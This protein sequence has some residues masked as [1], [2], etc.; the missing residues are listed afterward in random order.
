[1]NLKI[2]IMDFQILPIDTI[3][4][5]NTQSQIQQNEQSIETKKVQ[6]IS[7][8]E[9]AIIC[10]LLQLESSDNT[11]SVVDK[12]GPLRL[13][14]VNTQKKN[15]ETIL[16]STNGP[17]GDVVNIEEKKIVC[18][19]HGH[20]SICVTNEIKLNSEGKFDLT[21]DA[22]E[23][24]TFEISKCKFYQGFEGTVIRVFKHNGKVYYSSHKK[25]DTSKS[26]WGSSEN[27][28]SLFLRLS[29]LQETDLFGDEPSYFY[30]YVFIVVAPDLLVSSK[31][32]I[33]PGYVALVDIFSDSSFKDSDL[34]KAKCL[35]PREFVMLNQTNRTIRTVE[36]ELAAVNNILKFGYYPDVINEV[37][38]LQAGEFVMMH[39]EDKVFRVES[40]AYNWR[41]SV[42]GHDPN[43]I[44]RFY[45][46]LQVA[47]IDPRNKK[48]LESYLT[49]FEKI[50]F[51]PIQ[52]V[53]NQIFTV[54]PIVC[55]VNSSTISPLPKFTDRIS[56]IRNMLYNLLLAC[57][58]H[59]QKEIIKFD[60]MLIEDR[61]N[62]S[63]WIKQIFRGD[64]VL[65]DNPDNQKA[66]K[67]IGDIIKTA[68]S[69]VADNKP[70]EQTNRKHFNKKP[71]TN[72]FNSSVET[73]ISTLVS[74]ES[75]L[76]FY[77]ILRA[78]K[79]KDK[80]YKKKELPAFNI[81]KIEPK[82]ETV[83]L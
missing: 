53:K 52:N 29:G 76:S 43:L 28:R 10:E 80:E 55:W 69:I 71:F 78:Y 33:G 16:E 61:T 79:T 7:E 13:I 60:D 45:Y 75:G 58:I 35:P 72:S 40:I 2:E 77:K 34:C 30:N 21:T 14:H 66:H 65:N 15:G 25:L 38:K 83:E 6:P 9:R 46:L 62:V 48:D 39:Y 57:P 24:H 67:R 19:S 81:Q 31:Q 3:E 44:H 63:K 5:M 23:K 20:A 22:N 8:E 27:F 4:A 51:V 26:T 82:V 59:L 74:Q 11:W 32:F 50:P 56:L 1:M 68:R 17:R 73:M 70:K 47:N 36:L 64:G 42:R 18:R 37:T 41:C 49:L 12:D 54:E